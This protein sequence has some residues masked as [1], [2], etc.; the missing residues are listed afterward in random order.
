MHVFTY[1]NRFKHLKTVF[2]YMNAQILPAG[3]Q[4]PKNS[5]KK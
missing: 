1:F 3:R 5:G 2:F 4:G